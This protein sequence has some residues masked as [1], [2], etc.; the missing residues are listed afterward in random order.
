MSGRIGETTGVQPH[1][2]SN[3]IMDSVSAC[4]YPLWGEDGRRTFKV[5]ED[6]SSVSP[7]VHARGAC[8]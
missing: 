8:L 6:L 5:A 3:R 1:N 4:P 2:Y 7:V